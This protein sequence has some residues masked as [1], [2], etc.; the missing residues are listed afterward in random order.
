MLYKVGI[1]TRPIDQ[2]TSGSGSHL[3]QMVKYILKLNTKFEIYLIHYRK[4]DFD[5]YKNIN[6]I[7]IPR[8]PILAANILR[9]YNFN[10][11]HYSPLSIFSPIWGL[12]GKKIATIHG[13][14]EHFLPN[15]YNLLS[16]LHKKYI[17]KYYAQKM[18]YI[19]TVS[20]ESKSFIHQ[21]YKIP[22]NNIKLTY[23]SVDK[24][25]K[26]LSQLNISKLIF[27]KY[28]IS[29]RYIIHI[30]K[31][32]E[33][34]NPWVILKAFY[35][36]RKLSN[37]N[38]KIKLVI[39]GSGW[40]NMEVMK[41]IRKHNIIDYIIL[42]GFAPK[43]ELVSLLN[44]AEAFIF[45]SLYEGCGMPNLEAMACG[46]PVITSRAFAIPE[47]VGNAALMLDD[48]TN[49]RELGLKINTLLTNEKLRLNLIQ[50]GYERV[51]LYSW[52]T[53]ASI[54]LSIYEE[55]TKLN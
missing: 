27:T 18:N 23:N 32:S 47:I 54:A 5:I 2:Q 28:S 12:K 45:P 21:N 22:L 15:Q 36:F 16:V 41:F 10:V 6:E 50:K 34:K 9:Q 43:H 4:L 51:R 39:V 8:N 1:F 49:H 38:R 53:S 26:K 14:S 17:V 44:L 13:A 48:N 30:S 42:T 7:I 25:Y 33:R 52:E 35:F 29:N 3:R 24:D 20:K 19:F 31:Y 40:N 55:C 37:E 46:C 11:L